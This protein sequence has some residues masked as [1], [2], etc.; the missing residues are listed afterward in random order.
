MQLII[1]LFIFLFLIIIFS[2]AAIKLNN[3]FWHLMPVYHKYDFW[4]YFY[5]KKFIFGEL[6]KNKFYDYL[7]VSTNEIN[8]LDDNSKRQIIMMLQSHFLGN[9]KF[10]YKFDDKIFDATYNG[11]MTNSL[12]S[13]YKKQKF[14]FEN[15]EIKLSNDYN[16][17]GVILAKKINIVLNGEYINSYLLDK[18]CTHREDSNTL[19]KRKLLFTHIYNSLQSKSIDNFIIKKKINLF[20]NVIPVV[21]SKTYTYNIGYYSKPNMKLFEIK[22]IESNIDPIISL[23]STLTNNKYYDILFYT[24]IGNIKLMLS[25]KILEI[26]TLN[27]KGHILAYYIFKSSHILDENNEKEYLSCISSINNCPTESIFFNGFLYA[28]SDIFKKHP[29]KSI[30]QMENFSQNNILISYLNQIYN[31]ISITDTAFYSINLFVPN[32]PINSNNCFTLI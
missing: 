11:I 16:I 4:R 12:C 20:K 5:K 29:Q 28:L 8:S 7:Q 19:I 22:K 25:E 13:I 17:E 31:S 32:S 10:L 1:T 24:D 2:I 3:P 6:Y 9:D 26:Y 23:I 14:T 30:I 21:S 15:N 27:Y 18:I